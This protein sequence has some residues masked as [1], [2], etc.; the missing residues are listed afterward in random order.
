MPV[1]DDVITNIQEWKGK[2]ISVQPV[3]GGLTNANYKVLVDGKPYFVRV[4][5]ESTELLAVD[6]RNEYFNTCAAA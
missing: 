2:S 5:G 4:P 6:R 3:S 1:I